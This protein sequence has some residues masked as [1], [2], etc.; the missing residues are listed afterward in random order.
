M[1][2]VG[3]DPAQRRRFAFISSN[4]GW[5]GSEELW[6]LAALAL[7]E[8]GHDVTVM[9][10]ELETN[11]PAIRRLKELDCRLIDLKRI[12][13][14]PA[15]LIKL[16]VM[17]AWPASYAVQALRLW[18]A[19]RRPYDLVIVSQG[20]NFDGLFL[21]KRVRRKGLPYVIISQ[22]AGEMYWPYDASIDDMRAFF[23]DARA[24]Y[25][26]SQHNLRLTEQQLG[27]DLPR[28]S[29]VRNPFLVPW[30]RETGWPSDEEGLRLAC[31]GRLYPREKGQDLLLLVLAREKWRNR[32]LHVSFYGAG[33][34]AKALQDTA[35]YYGLK[36]VSFPGFTEE[37]ASIWRTHHGLVLPS[38]CEGLPLVVVEAMMCGRIPIVT[39]VAG[40]REVVDDG[41]NGF[42]AAAP[43]ED[44]LDEA[45]EQAWARRA[46]WRALGDQAALDIRRLVPQDPAATLAGALRAAAT[47]RR[48]L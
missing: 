24:C 35:A 44:S 19:L 22:K 45:M 13:L 41:T 9:K 43:T 47:P 33:V 14:I 4:A 32:P 6:S 31:V 42:L 15:A 36:S 26:V 17:M 38:R 48:A 12:P 5:G 39:D 34:H 7:A 29:V 11:Q 46:E 21:G 37:A 1:H 8:R 30:E 2:Q 10:G 28:A 16:V 18:F 27:R 23:G 20:A 3:L 25:F 40:N